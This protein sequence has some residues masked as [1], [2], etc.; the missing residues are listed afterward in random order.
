MGSVERK[1]YGL[2]AGMISTMRQTGQTMGIAIGTM[3]LSIFV[4]K[5]QV[6]P[7]KL[8]HFMSA[9]RAAFLVSTGLSFMGIF[10]S[11]ARGNAGKAADFKH[12]KYKKI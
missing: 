7:E 9:V 1:Y 12:D 5:T 2:A 6:T 10:A 3:M 8:P 11:L 4:G